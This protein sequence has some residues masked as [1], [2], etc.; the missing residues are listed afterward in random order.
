[1][2]GTS[3]PSSKECPRLKLT[4][5]K[6]KTTN[7]YL[8]AIKNTMVSIKGISVPSKVF[9]ITPQTHKLELYDVKSCSTMEVNI[10]IGL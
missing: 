9:F 4:K 7:F 5:K 6:L 10:V 2:Q 8:N 3:P 1:M